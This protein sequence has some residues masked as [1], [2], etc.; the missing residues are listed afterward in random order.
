[1]F[2]ALQILRRICV[3][4]RVWHKNLLGGGVEV[5]VVLLQRL[6]VLQLSGQL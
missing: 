5:V 1:L 6:T 3:L 2:T 4:G